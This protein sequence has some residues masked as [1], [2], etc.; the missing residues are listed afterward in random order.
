M[1]P[2]IVI[3]SANASSRWKPKLP[4]KGQSVNAL[5]NKSRVPP[6]SARA[7]ADRDAVICALRAR[8]GD[9]VSRT[10]CFGVGGVGGQ[11]VQ[12]VD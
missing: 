12:G 11:G 4:V 2:A 1:N 6:A 9:E 5:V 10:L 8:N 3:V 7:G